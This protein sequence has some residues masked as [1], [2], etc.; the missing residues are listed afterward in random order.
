MNPGISHFRKKRAPTSVS[1]IRPQHFGAEPALNDHLKPPTFTF[2]ANSNVFGIVFFVICQFKHHHSEFC[3]WTCCIE[4]L[5][6]HQQEFVLEG[7]VR[8]TS[9]FQ[10]YPIQSNRNRSSSNEFNSIQS[11]RSQSNRNQSESIESN[12]IETKD[13]LNLIS[14]LIPSN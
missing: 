13:K 8:F 1:N 3:S 9:S 7:Q 6:E 5:Q 11:N 10:S 2:L 4:A 12:L 14:T